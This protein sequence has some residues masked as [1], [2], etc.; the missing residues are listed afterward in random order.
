MTIHCLACAPLPHA[1]SVY[2]ACTL[3]LTAIAAT[4]ARHLFCKALLQ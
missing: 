2:A 4:F 1:A 3:P